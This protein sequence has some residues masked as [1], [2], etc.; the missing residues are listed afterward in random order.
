M[1]YV[2]LYK[3][4]LNTLHWHSWQQLMDSLSI[5]KLTNPL[6]VVAKIKE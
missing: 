2:F 4:Q 3:I 1:D 5:E 6:L